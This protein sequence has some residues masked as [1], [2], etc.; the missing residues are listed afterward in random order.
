MNND[1]TKRLCVRNGIDIPS[2][3]FQNPLH[4]IPFS[5][6]LPDGVESLRYSVSSEYL[7]YLQT[8]T[9]RYLEKSYQTFSPP[10][11]TS[12]SSETKNNVLGK[13]TADEIIAFLDKPY[14][15]CDDASKPSSS[16]SSSTLSTT[17]LQKTPTDSSLQI[18]PP[19]P[20]TKHRQRKEKRPRVGPVLKKTAEAVFVSAHASLKH[21]SMYRINTVHVSRLHALVLFLR[22]DLPSSQPPYIATSLWNNLK[23]LFN[24]NNLIYVR[25]FNTK[26]GLVLDFPDCYDGIIHSQVNNGIHKVVKHIPS[27]KTRFRWWGET[28][29]VGYAPMKNKTVSDAVSRHHFMLP[30]C[31][32]TN[33][34]IVQL[35]KD[36]N[37]KQLLTSISNI[38]LIMLHQLLGK[39]EYNMWALRGYNAGSAHVVVEN[40][41]AFDNIEQITINYFKS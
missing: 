2:I 33:R 34:N 8:L 35:F 7:L 30:E 41:L 5:V 31:I 20:P 12:T 28:T 32:L 24:T 22:G 9:S 27:K 6:T 39:D 13:E 15:A 14:T 11:P 25:A 36:N 21:G 40:P 1:S 37:H 26:E 10:L 18:L 38:I 29:I 3:D 19:P 4:C 16:C 17:A 23:D